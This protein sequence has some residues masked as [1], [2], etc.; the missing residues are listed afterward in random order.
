M[1]KSIRLLIIAFLIL[2]FTFLYAHIAKNIYLYDRNT[3]A[4][5]YIG[6]GILLDGETITQT[7][8]SKEDVIDGINLKASVAGNPADIKLVYKITDNA[9]GAS[10]KGTI[11]GEKIKNN[12]FNE[13]DIKSIKNAKGKSYTLLLKGEGAD[14][15]KGFSFY[16]DPAGNGGEKLTVKGNDTKG[17]LVVRTVTHRFDLETF[18]V[19]LG[20]ILFVIVFIKVLYKLFK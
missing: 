7:F 5:N 11:S 4:E 3:E 12:K 2:A 15:S 20:F 10:V 1:K 18:V 6:T 9:S 8:V 14:N 13:L 19:L 17:S 16:I